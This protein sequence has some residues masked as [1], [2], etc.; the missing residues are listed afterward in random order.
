MLAEN[1][2]LSGKANTNQ[3]VKGEDDAIPRS[4]D[5]MYPIESAELISGPLPKGQGY[6]QSTVLRMLLHLMLLFTESPAQSAKEVKELIALMEQ[7]YKLWPSEVSQLWE[8]VLA[9]DS[10]KQTERRPP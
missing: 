6:I 8:A 4:M 3:T 5:E 9:K 1:A 7:L 2:R 10:L